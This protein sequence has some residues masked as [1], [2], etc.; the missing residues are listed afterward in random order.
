[1]AT[2]IASP[3]TQL[4][5][6]DVIRRHV[7][8]M[9][10]VALADEEM[11]KIA[12]DAAKKRRV[13]R[14]LEADLADEQAKRKQQI[15]ELQKE[16]DTHDRELDTGEQERV[17]LCDEIF[18]AGTVY[19]RRSDTGEE[20]EPR[21]AS[22]QEAQRYLPAVE[23]TLHTLPTDRAAPLLD[24]AAAAQAATPANDDAPPD[25]DADDDSDAPEDDGLAEPL[26]S[27]QKAARE[28]ERARAKRR[29]AGAKSGKGGGK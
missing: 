5:P 19:V 26:T 4:P 25:D 7:K 12:I 13:L 29:K 28:S 9:L 18:R 15:K 20:F 23:S 21:P 1:M 24:Q 22:A 11:L 17:V 3:P 10:P 16:I 14:Q 27:A 8:R 2:A 6:A